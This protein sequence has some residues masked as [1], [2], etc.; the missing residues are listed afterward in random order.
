MLVQ[1]L[2]ICGNMKLIVDGRETNFVCEGSI[3]LQN[4][5][6]VFICLLV[7]SIFPIII[8]K[9]VGPITA[10]KMCLL[11]YIHLSGYSWHD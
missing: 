8:I 4:N 7:Q 5:N 10:Y 3:R 9:F 2:I 6:Y 11:L 1:I